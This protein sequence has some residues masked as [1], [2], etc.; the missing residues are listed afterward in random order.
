MSIS[1][2]VK[3]LTHQITATATTRYEA[4]LDIQNYL[5]SSRF[6]YDTNIPVDRSSNAL[7][8]FL[9]HSRRGFCQQFATAMA[10]MARL[11]GIPSRVAVGFTPGTHLPGST[12]WT[13]TTH[14]AHA[15]PELWFEGYGW[16]PF[17]PT[18]RHDGQATTPGYARVAASAGRKGAPKHPK[19]NPTA[20]PRLPPGLRPEPHPGGSTGGG[21]AGLRKRHHAG[22]VAGQIVLLVVVLLALGLMVPGTA[23]AIT[24]RRRWRH[25]SDPLHAPAAAWAELRDTAI[26]LR[27]PWNDGRTPRQVAAGLLGS[28]GPAPGAAEALLRLAKSEE[29]ARYAVAPGADG[30]DLREDIL[31]IR[32]AARATCSG[33]QRAL[34]TVLPRSTMMTTGAALARVAESV[35][36]IGAPIQ[37]ALRHRPRLARS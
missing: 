6:T 29:R 15:W 20:S 2:Q 10:V 22:G 33:P 36:A 32:A 3:T 31:L 9:L 16:L 11:S 21:T 28:L 17:E 7:A 23:R 1:P 5:T 18:P 4:A 19:A 37:R 34:A 27:L 35:E 25:M 24:R 14:D 12:T 8:N 13:V 30:A 26:D